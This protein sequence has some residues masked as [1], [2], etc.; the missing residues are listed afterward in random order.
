MDIVKVRN[1][2]IGKGRPK[3]CVPIVSSSAEEILQDAGN[4][5]RLGADLAEWRADW[6]EDVS[7]ISKVL[8]TAGKLREILGEFPLLFTFRTSKEGGE[9]SLGTEEYVA[10]N[11]AVAASGFVDLLDVELFTGDQE[12]ASLISYAHECQVRVIVSSHDFRKTPSRETILGRLK[13]MQDLG[14]DIPKIA[15]MPQV[16]GDVLALLSAT[17]EMSEQYAKGPII[18][19]SM[20][21]AGVV[22]RLAGETF[23]SAVT[24]GAAK[25]RSAP[26]QVAVEDL[27]RVLDVIHESQENG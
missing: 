17:L 16:K 3:I 1:V 14:A 13:K 7:D 9:R 27:V 20:S 22:S 19:M 26:G 5:C 24:Y 25:K 8:D 11:R 21:G 2:I 23:G 6:Y 4:F 18:T 10:L 12:V 15:V